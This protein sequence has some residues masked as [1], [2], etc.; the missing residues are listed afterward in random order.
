VLPAP[1]ALRA[2]ASM[3]PMTT[4]TPRADR[5][6]ASPDGSETLTFLETSADTGRARTYLEA[7]IAPGTGTPPHVHGSFSEEFEVLEGTLLVELG[8]RTLHLGPGERAFV[9]IGATHRFANA[10]AERVVFRCA[11]EPASRGFEEAQQIGAGLAAEG[12]CRGEIPKDP[13]ALGVLVELS[14]SRLTGPAAIAMPVLRALGALC[15][16]QGMLDDLRARHV[17][18]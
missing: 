16:R 2:A 17:R 9:P 6:V 13:R 3:A 4:T 18:W 14:D 1:R 5:R 10:T 8:G 12:R 15:R 11:L 7:E